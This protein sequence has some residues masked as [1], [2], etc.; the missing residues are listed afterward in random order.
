MNVGW[1]HLCTLLLNT[2]QQQLTW[3]TT[4]VAYG[5]P[6]RMSCHFDC[7]RSVRKKER[8]KKKTYSNLQH[9]PPEFNR[10]FNE[11]LTGWCPF[12]CPPLIAT[13]SFRDD[14][15]LAF[16]GKV[17]KAKS[18][19]CGSSW[20]CLPLVQTGLL[21]YFLTLMRPNTSNF[22]HRGESWG[23]FT[24]ILYV[25]TLLIH[26]NRCEKFRINCAPRLDNYFISVDLCP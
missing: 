17:G 8:E 16:G 20:W 25:G 1:R 22:F 12:V 11:D 9:T 3:Q 26:R 24:N 23:L 4:E 19:S 21:I 2:T 14:N 6:P 13:R 10:Q 7:S 18:L 15:K 5:R